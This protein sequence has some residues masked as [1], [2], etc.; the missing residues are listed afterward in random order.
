V[1]AGKR[2]NTLL[3][4]IL[5][6]QNYSIQVKGFRRHHKAIMQKQSVLCAVCVLATY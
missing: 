5:S 6:Q 2:T 1:Q 4:A 3:T